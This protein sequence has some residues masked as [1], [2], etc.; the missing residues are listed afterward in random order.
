MSNIHGVGGV[1]PP[2][3]SSPKV[4]R[5]QQSQEVH[6]K[7]DEISISANSAKVAEIA[8]VS[9]LAKASP[10]IRTDIVSRAKEKVASGEYLTRETSRKVA[11]KILESL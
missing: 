5:V 11:E 9:E 3:F 7:S 8:Q 6:S 2:E 4:R 1:Q 10:D